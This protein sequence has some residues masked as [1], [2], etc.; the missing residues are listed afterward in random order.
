MTFGGR[1][2]L[3]RQLYDVVDALADLTLLGPYV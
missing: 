2:K 1:D 3:R